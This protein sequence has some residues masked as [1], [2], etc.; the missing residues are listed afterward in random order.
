MARLCK[1]TSSPKDSSLNGLSLSTQSLKNLPLPSS[2]LRS[3]IPKNPG[4]CPT[5]TERGTD[6]LIRLDE[7]EFASFEIQAFAFRDF[8]Q[9]DTRRQSTAPTQSSEITAPQSL[10]RRL[11]RKRC[12][13]DLLAKAGIRADPGENNGDLDIPSGGIRV[14]IAVTVT[15]SPTPVKKS[16][17]GGRVADLVR[18][19]KGPTT[20]KENGVEMFP[21]P[22][23]RKGF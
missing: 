18:G 20:A 15:S 11:L 22:K 2:S 8:L 19:G 14:T 12:W 6:S 13:R 17:L 21:Y 23:G 10:K 4:Q 9:Q 1:S 3:P 5:L 16:G 7:F